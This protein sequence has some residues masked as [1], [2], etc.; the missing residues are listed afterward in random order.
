VKQ[1]TAEW[2]GALAR[3]AGRLTLEYFGRGGESRDKGARLG[4]VTEADLASEK[5]IRDRVRAAFPGHS[6]LG[7]EGGMDAGAVDALWLVD[8]LDGT[9][10]F[11]KG[12]SY[13][14]VSVAFAV[15]GQ[16]RVGVV[17]RPVTD[18]LF[19]AEHGAGAWVGSRRLTVAEIPF[20][21][22]SYATGFGA[23]HGVELQ[24]GLAQI[25][26]VQEAC[27][28]TAV[29]VNGAAALDLSGVAAGV[30][31]GFWEAGLNAWDTAAGSLLVRE[32]GGVVSGLSGS[33]FDVLHDRGIVCGSRASHPELLRL[34][35]N[36]HPIGKQ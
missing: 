31:Q 28:S 4:F 2:V 17:Y 8:P 13:Y 11:S 35:G 22:G 30:F 27:V 24:R 33:E 6:V 18:E 34:L 21:Q 25:G 32:A 29:R 23:A 16:V 3:E 5:L 19:V 7:E 14:C 36:H 9:N 20:E 1:P 15:A 12:N 10:N 26:R